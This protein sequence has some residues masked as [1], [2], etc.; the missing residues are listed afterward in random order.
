ME[1]VAKVEYILTDY[2]GTYIKKLLKPQIVIKAGIKF[3]DLYLWL[4]LIIFTI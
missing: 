3:L 2:V 4:C 1:I